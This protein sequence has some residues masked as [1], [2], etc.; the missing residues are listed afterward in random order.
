MDRIFH[1]GVELRKAFLPQSVAGNGTP[2]NGVAVDNDIKARDV[3]FLLSHGDPGA[4]NTSELNVA[5]EGSEDGSTWEAVP[6]KDGND[7]VFDTINI[8]GTADDS[9]A[10]VLMGTVPAE[11]LPYRYYRLVVTNTNLQDA[12]TV[13][14]QALLVDVLDKYTAQVDGLLDK[15]LPDGTVL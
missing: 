5:V 7:L 6:D 11:R 14:A 1:E 4:G 3:A 2:V 12:V 8:I 13:G 9:A 10:A 15:V